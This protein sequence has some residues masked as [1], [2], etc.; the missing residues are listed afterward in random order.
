MYNL[1]SITPVPV[2]ILVCTSTQNTC[3][4]QVSPT[5]QHVHVHTRKHAWNNGV[6]ATVHEAD[7]D[8]RCSTRLL[9]STQATTF[10]TP[11]ARTSLYP[12]PETPIPLNPPSHLPKPQNSSWTEGKRSFTVPTLMSIQSAQLWRN[13]AQLHNGPLLSCKEIRGKAAV[14]QSLSRRARRRLIPKMHKVAIHCGEKQSVNA[15]QP[16]PTAAHH[17]IT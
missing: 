5:P 8:A 7:A 14:Q 2:Y 6:A 16:T 17:T 4:V 9:R 3:L 15:E 13:S 12:L 1:V 10:S 11:N